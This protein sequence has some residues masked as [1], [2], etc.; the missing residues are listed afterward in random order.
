M[1]KVESFIT[2]VTTEFE[3][4]PVATTIK[5]LVVLWVLKQA[6]NLV[7]ETTN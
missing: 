1:E 3:K 4:K 7:K 6:I 2:K 5:G